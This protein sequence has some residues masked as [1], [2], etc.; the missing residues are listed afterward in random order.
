M[1][2][3][4]VP[5]K[6]YNILAAGKPIL[7]IGD[8]RSEIARMVTEADVGWVFPDHGEALVTFIRSLHRDGRDA[9]GARG[10]RARALAVSRYGEARQLQAYAA[11]ITPP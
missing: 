5:S 4:G 3:L 10:S 2:G 8:P 7:F 1:L 9:L 11:R 6:A